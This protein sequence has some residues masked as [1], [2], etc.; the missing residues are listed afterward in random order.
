MT[1]AVAQW[2]LSGDYFENCNCDVVCPCEI[3]ALGPLTAR[4]TQGA[5]EVA[6][7]FHIDEGRYGDVTLNDLNVVVMGRAP[8]PMG[9]GNWSVALYI[10]ERGNQLQR[11]ALQAIFS[12]A[13]G[14]VMAGFAPLISQV[15][16]VKHVPISYRRDDKRR[17]VEI[18]GLLSMA[19]RPVQSMIPDQEMLAVGMHAI[20]PQGVAFAVGEEGSIW[21]DYGMRWDNSGKNGHYAPITWSN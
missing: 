10:D 11:D 5:C 14:G 20:N 1:Q 18:P 2:R 19:V 21:S 16:G 13:A 8:G 12:G 15:L 7:A 17:S 9:A 6:L 4:P 3:S